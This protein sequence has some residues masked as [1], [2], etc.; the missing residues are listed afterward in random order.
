MTAEILPLLFQRD[1]E[2]LKLEISS[3]TN[4]EDIWAVRENI[5]NSGGNLCLHLT[6]NLKYFIGKMLGGIAYERDRDKEFTDKNIPVTL[7]LS[8]LD[9]TSAAVKQ[10][11]ENLTQEDLLKPFPSK[12]LG[13]EMTTGYF[14]LHLYGHLNYHL[15][16]INYHRR[17]LNH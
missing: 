14:L 5:T 10:T 13:Y 17:L 2:K 6:G 9:E 7:L 8:A 1:L 12:V 3:Y 11:L 15:G 4:E 16:Q